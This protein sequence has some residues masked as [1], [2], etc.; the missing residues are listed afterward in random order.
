MLV[1][2]FF[3]FWAT[4][5][6]IYFQKVIWIE[7]C[8]KLKFNSDKIKK[9]LKIYFCLPLKKTKQQLM[10][11]KNKTC[12]FLHRENLIFWF[13]KIKKKHIWVLRNIFNGRKSYVQACV[14]CT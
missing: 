3:L 5:F 2:Q 1:A 7:I 4:F 9:S 12:N 10:P 6:H 11:Y 8:S 14:F 13:L